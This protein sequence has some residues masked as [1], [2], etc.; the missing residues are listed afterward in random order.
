MY[1]QFKT[2]CARY[3]AVVLVKQLLDTR[4]EVVESLKIHLKHAQLLV[5]NG[6]IAEVER[7][8]AEAAYDK[9]RV[10]QEKSANDLLISQAGLTSLLQE[11]QPAFPSSP[12]F[13]NP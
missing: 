6:Q 13:I 3:F 8:Q 5:D 2:L 1:D 9:A 11:K 10:E 7:L 12:L 4:T